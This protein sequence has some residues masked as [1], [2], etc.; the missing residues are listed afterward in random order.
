MEFSKVPCSIAE[1]ALKP[2]RDVSQYVLKFLILK[3]WA[4]DEYTYTKTLI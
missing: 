3:I 4:P 2:V 1:Y